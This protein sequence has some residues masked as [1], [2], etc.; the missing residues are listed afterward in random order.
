MP[1]TTR[2]RSTLGKS[3]YLNF[4][5]VWFWCNLRILLLLSMSEFWIIQMLETWNRIVCPSNHW[6]KSWGPHPKEW[7]EV[8]GARAYIHPGKFDER[9]R[10]SKKVPFAYWDFM[11]QHVLEIYLP[12]KLTWLAGKSSLNES[13]YFLLNMGIFQPVM[14]VFREI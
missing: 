8:S 14:I 11:G 3:T 4:G 5:D 7:L 12:W 9:I 10:I 1:S 2:A 13:M 6:Y